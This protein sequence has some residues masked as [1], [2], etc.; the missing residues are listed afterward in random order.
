MKHFPLSCGR[1]AGHLL[2]IGT[3]RSVL[4]HLRLLTAKTAR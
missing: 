4:C 2:L 1:L 3:L